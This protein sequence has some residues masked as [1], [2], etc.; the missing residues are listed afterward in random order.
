MMFPY[1]VS[2]ITATCSFG[3]GI[4]TQRLYEALQV[5]EH[6]ILYIEYGH[7]KTMTVS[8]GY[9]KKLDMRRQSGRRFDNQT[10]VVLQLYDDVFK[11]SLLTN[12]K[13]FKN[14]NVQMTG[15]KHT[16]QGQRV[17]LHLLNIIPP[18]VFADT[19]RSVSQYKVRLINCDFR[20]GY[21]IKRDKLCSIIQTQ[22]NTYCSFE[23]CIYPGVKVQYCYNDEYDP[24]GSCRCT[25][26]CTGKGIGSGNGGCKR[27]TISVFQSGCIIITGG[28]NHQQMRAAYDFICFVLQKHGDEVKRR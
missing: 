9:H 25:T 12:C 2:T 18:D 19:D 26:A 5:N 15:L 16:E 10:T 8:K 27:V 24:D 22:Y 6:G 7:K 20:I 11:T 13:I 1:K 17:A 21:Q 14:G 4:N 23:P 28:L 3:C